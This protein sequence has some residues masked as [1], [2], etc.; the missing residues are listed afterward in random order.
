MTKI[1]DEFEKWLITQDKAPAP[2]PMNLQ[3][4]ALAEIAF[5]AGYESAQAILSQGEP[6]AYLCYLGTNMSDPSENSLYIGNEFTP[7]AFPVYRAPPSTEALQGEPIGYFFKHLGVWSQITSEFTAEENTPL[8][9]SPPSTEALQKDKAELI[10]YAK[11]IKNALICIYDAQYSGQN[12]NIISTV[13]M[14][15]L[16]KEVLAIQKP[17]SME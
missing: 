9:L 2:A 16:A 13:D 12:K 7:N 10:E 1:I 14:A 6:V 17:K 5:E 3:A 8:Y 4:L 11:Y 15:N